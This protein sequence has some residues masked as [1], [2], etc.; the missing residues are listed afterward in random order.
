MKVGGVL[1]KVKS[2]AAIILGNA[3]F[4]LAVAAFVIPNG[5]LM[6]GI[7]GVGIVIHKLFGFDTA[8][9]VLIVNAVLMFIGLFIL[10]KKFFFST[11]VSSIIYPLF[12]ELF[13]S[14]PLFQ[15]KLT[16][17]NL[18]AAVF[19]GVLLGAAIGLLMR[20]GSSSGGTDI[21]GLIV[22]KYTH[23]GVAVIVW[24]AD[25]TVIGFQ[26]LTSSSE[27]LLLGIITIVIES[28]VLDKVMVLGK[29]QLQVFVISKKYEEIR[30][31]VLND[32][33]IG[34]TMTSIET[35]LKGEKQMGVM[36]II[37]KRSLYSLTELI[38]SIDNEAFVTVTKVKEVRGQGF[39][40]ERKTK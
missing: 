24:A 1:K 36:C 34:A 7:T 33:N 18:L 4:A 35:G 40:T 21:I 13:Q 9:F 16:D 28:Y 22:N 15:K 19:A 17:D 39:S 20:Q 11:V 25:I 32:L 30:S 29:A 26:A 3:L 37:H 27:A 38:N 31:A 23:V 2:T 14:L 5:I 6:G 12:L 10:G 8:L